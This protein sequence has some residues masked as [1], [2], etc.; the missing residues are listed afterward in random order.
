[1]NKVRQLINKYSFILLTLFCYVLLFLE[2]ENII[3]VGEENIYYFFFLFFI[4]LCIM[5]K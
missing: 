3:S 1:M 5:Q 4:V 2:Y